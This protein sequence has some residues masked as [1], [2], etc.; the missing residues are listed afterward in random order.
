MPATV[1]LSQALLERW[2][3]VERRSGEAKFSM[4]PF[5]IFWQIENGYCQWTGVYTNNILIFGLTVCF[6]VK[7]RCSGTQT[8]RKGFRAGYLLIYS[9]CLLAWFRCRFC[10]GNGWPQW[11]VNKET[12]LRQRGSESSS[13]TACPQSW[14]G[15]ACARGDAATVGSRG[16]FLQVAVLCGGSDRPHYLSTQSNP[17]VKQHFQS[18]PRMWPVPENYPEG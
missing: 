5:H 4:L 8:L 10:C 13:M 17:H 15:P 14:A 11:H 1:E 3:P 2:H 12:L 6:W 9:I 7:E 16:H 18:V